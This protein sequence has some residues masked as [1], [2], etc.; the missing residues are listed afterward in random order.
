MDNETCQVTSDEC[1]NGSSPAVTAHLP[2]VDDSND[3]REKRTT[4]KGRR[5]GSKGKNDDN[6]RYCVQ[7]CIHSATLRIASCI[8]D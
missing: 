1:S 2:T 4:K 7:N 6:W 8:K 3:A 5:K